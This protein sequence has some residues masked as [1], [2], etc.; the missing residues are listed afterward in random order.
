MLRAAP[1][2]GLSRSGLALLWLRVDASRGARARHPP[3]APRTTATLP[4]CA[5]QFGAG[6]WVLIDGYGWGSSTSGC[7]DNKDGV[8]TTKGYGWIPLFGATLVFLM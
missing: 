6:W 5:L 1:R 8:N 7:L 2:G 3:R 4:R